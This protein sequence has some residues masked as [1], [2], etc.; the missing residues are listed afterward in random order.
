M[1][2]ALTWVGMSPELLRVAERAKR[3]PEGQ[4]HSLAHLLDES[5]LIHA[6]SR[7]RKNAAV[8][9]DGVTKEYYGQ[10]LENNIRDLHQ[11]LRSKRYRH[12]PIRR[13]HIPKDNGKTRPLGISAF[14]DKLVQDAVRAVL[15]AVYEQDFLDCSYGFRPGRGAH[16]AIRALHRTVDRG[17][18]NWVLE[19]DI[20]SFL[21]SAC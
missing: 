15:Q 18:V 12:Q 14:E 10:D 8:G 17:E 16:D 13:V 21:D 6:Y 20:V 7:Q 4:F 1:S 9:V 5:A 2:Q 11:R 3:E 19:A